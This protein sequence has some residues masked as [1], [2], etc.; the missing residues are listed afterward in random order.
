MIYFIEDTSSA[1]SPSGRLH[2]PRVQLLMCAQCTPALGPAFCMPSAQ[3][4]SGPA[5]HACPVHTL[6]PP[7]PAPHVCPVHAHP[8]GLVHT[9]ASACAAP[10]PAH[11]WLSMWL[12]ATGPSSPTV[13]PLPPHWPLPLV[14]RPLSHTDHCPSQAADC[15]LGFPVP[16][17]GHRGGTQGVFVERKEENKGEEKS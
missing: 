16:C 9:V 15:S 17:A 10:H 1:Q 13:Y 2:C 6:L 3:P 7:G 4:A 12:S 14:R 11:P 5:P 8:G